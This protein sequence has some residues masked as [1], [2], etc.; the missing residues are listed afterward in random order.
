MSFTPSDDAIQMLKRQIELTDE[1]ARNLLI[2]HKGNILKALESAMNGDDG[3][4]IDAQENTEAEEID[5]NE[6]GVDP[7]KRIKQ[8]RNILDEKDKIF[9][10]HVKK[11]FN[12]ETDA[13]RT[14]DY[15]AWK[16][17]TTTFRK[18]TTKCTVEYFIN[19]VLKS[20]IVGASV[21]PVSDTPNPKQDFLKNYVNRIEIKN[22]QNE[23]NAMLAKWKFFECAIAYK[24]QNIHKVTSSDNNIDNF[25]TNDMNALGTKLLRKSNIISDNEYYSGNIVVI[26][27]WKHD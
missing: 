2:K 12:E 18:D 11:D 15:V 26:H 6:N 19:D 13:V 25:I 4:S 10:Q 3:T 7:K 14:F 17:D 21:V 27:N 8:F 24:K 9:M 16:S 20:F 23:S 5:I 22:L 1:S